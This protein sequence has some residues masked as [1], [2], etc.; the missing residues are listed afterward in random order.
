MNTQINSNSL[1]QAKL[2][3]YIDDVGNTAAS[4]LDLIFLFLS[5]HFSL[6]NLLSAASCWTGGNLSLQQSSQVK[7]PLF[8]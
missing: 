4:A 5:D 8:I 2:D 7:S 3:L 1:K 6:I